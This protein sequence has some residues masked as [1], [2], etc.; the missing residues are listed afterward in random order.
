MNDYQIYVNGKQDCQS[1]TNGGETIRKKTM[2]KTYGGGVA[3]GFC[4]VRELTLSP[5]A[6]P[7][8]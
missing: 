8:T 5:P 1:Q 7:V 4:D 6:L 2:E 3:S